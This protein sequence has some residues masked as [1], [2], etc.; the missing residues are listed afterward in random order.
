MAVLGMMLAL[1]VNSATAPD[2]T[3]GPGKYFVAV[4]GNDEWSGSQPTPNADR[5][6]GPFATID[7]AL[8]EHRKGTVRTVVFVR[9]GTHHLAQ[10]ITLTPQD[11]GLR[12][13]A[14][15]S[16]R[17]ILSGGRA[18]TGWKQSQN[19]SIWTASVPEAR[20]NRWH[21]RTLRV[22][23]EQQTLARHPNIE[24]ANPIQ[25]GW[26]FVIGETKQSGAFGAALSKIHTA[27][28]W[29]EWGLKV[30]A[31]GEYRLWL[32]Y[33]S[34][35]RGADMADRTQVQVDGGTPVPLKNLP[36]SP[37]PRWSPVASLQLTQGDH[38][39]RWTNVKGGVLNLDALLIT[40]D[41]AWN[42]NVRG[43]RPGAGRQA[44]TIQAESF[45]GSQSK[46]MVVPET[47]SAAFR[48]RFQFKLGDVKPYRSPEPEIH[49]F[50]GEGTASTVLYALRIDASA[51]VV[52]VDPRI[53]TGFDL[54]PGNRY[55]VANVIEELDSPGEWYLDRAQ[56]NLYHWPKSP[57]FERLGVVAAALDR[58]I[59]IKGDPAKNQWVDEVIIQGF[60][61][62]DTVWSKAVN[63]LI[64]S[65]AAIWLSGARKCVIEGNLFVNLGG[66][67]VRIEAS[68][69]QNEIV[70]NHITDMGQGGVV[71]L[72]DNST[73]PRDNVIAG[74]WMQR[75][76]RV[77][78]HVGG[79][80]CF[81]AGG[82][83]VAHNRIEQVPRFAI[84][85]QSVDARTQ[86]HGNVAE[87]NDIQYACMETVDSG[88]IE[89]LGPHKV[90]TGNV[91]QFNRIADVSGLTT[92]DDGRFL[93]SQGVS[94]IQLAGFA[95]GVTVRGNVI[96]RTPQGA[97]VID[98]GK[99]NLMEQNLCIDGGAQQVLFEVRDAHC[100]NNRL[101]RN[102]FFF[103]SPTAHLYKH[104]NAWNAKIV[105]ECDFNFYWHAQGG[106]FYD[107]AVTPL[108][109][110]A[111]W[112]STGLDRNSSVADPAFV[113]AAKGNFELKAESPARQRGFQPLDQAK[114]GL[115]GH[116]RAWKR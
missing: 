25:G 77:F 99:N 44:V 79:V 87:Y 23:N 69:S 32:L 66:N 86:S 62:S 15:P 49:I 46:E 21:M 95:S 26:S 34:Y 113:D 1:T 19:P 35:N 96:A 109:N 111:Q 84:A 52:Q 33:Q 88:A 53:N 24:P 38:V 41:M 78:R 14:Y 90:D 61:F 103:T 76:G 9:A 16:E 97:V 31:D 3:P 98:G 58:L 2:A 100:E 60:Q 45:L 40:D 112:Q 37:A 110:V 71:L 13:L 17:P 27:G 42:P 116:P 5:S 51:R 115:P 93:A 20:A 55:F 83:R 8:K 64:P 94:G 65:D 12:L 63:V 67:A 30:P 50:P 82:T 101:L 92:S 104:A 108:G 6:D 107:R 72:G 7:R 47:A 91:I 105:S 68:S 73:Q 81:T 28:D 54:R 57:Q 48:D 74:N 10:P 89:V 114:V 75:L 39:L 59:E 80:Y 4:N 70:G 43:S 11:S 22:G 56:G 36:D 29:I 85:F 102:I 18:I 106:A